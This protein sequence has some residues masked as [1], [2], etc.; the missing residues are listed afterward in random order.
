MRT[1][2]MTIQGHVQGVGFRFFTQTTAVAYDIKGW[3]RN[4]NN[5]D[6]ELEAEGPDR[7]METFIRKI[8]EGPRFSKVEHVS[9]A[10]LPEPKGYTEF[11]ITN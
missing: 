10:D 2:A 6:V 4:L 3:V 7:Q 11:K 8:S 1:V 5:G 9:L